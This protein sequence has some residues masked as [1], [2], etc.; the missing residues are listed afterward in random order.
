MV[1]RIASLANVLPEYLTGLV[2][3]SAGKRSLVKK[4]ANP[5]IYTPPPNCLE[6]S[7]CLIITI[8]RA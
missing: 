3:P 8:T 7:A 2:V 6:Y 4:F 5:R 1:S